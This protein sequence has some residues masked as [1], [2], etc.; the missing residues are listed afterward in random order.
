MPFSHKSE[1]RMGSIYKIYVSQSEASA[2]ICLKSKNVFKK[3]SLYGNT[4]RIKCIKVTGP[5]NY[6][7]VVIITNSC[8]H[9]HP[10]K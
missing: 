5:F 2:G 3:A 9:F 4:Q 6:F 1:L 7:P 8:V 10:I